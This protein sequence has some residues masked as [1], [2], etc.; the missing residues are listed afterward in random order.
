MM[1]C[2]GRS[3]ISSTRPSGRPL[4]SCRTIRTG[5]VLVQHRA[6]LVGRQVNVG[7]AVVADQEAVAVAMSLNR[8]FNFIQQTAGGV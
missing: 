6:H 8:A 2:G 4:R 1:G 5:P 3:T 7:A